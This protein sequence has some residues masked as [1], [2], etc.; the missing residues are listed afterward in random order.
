M[1]SHLLNQI[2][3][4]SV[5]N[6]ELVAA[7]FNEDAAAWALNTEWRVIYQKVHMAVRKI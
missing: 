2:F 6:S 4:T 5:D 1:P 3:G 7:F